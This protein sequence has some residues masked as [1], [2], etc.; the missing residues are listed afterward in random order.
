VPLSGVDISVLDTDLRLCL[1]T[2]SET[3]NFESCSLYVDDK[4][5]YN[6]D[7]LNIFVHFDMIVK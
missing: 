7:I 2:S 1:I 5:N 4:V 3:P 6:M